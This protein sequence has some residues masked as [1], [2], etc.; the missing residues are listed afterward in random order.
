MTI[1]VSGGVFIGVFDDVIHEDP[2]EAQAAGRGRRT[3]KSCGR[4]AFAEG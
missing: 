2:D 1:R 3:G 4:C